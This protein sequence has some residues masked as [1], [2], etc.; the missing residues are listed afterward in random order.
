MQNNDISG[1]AAVDRDDGFNEPYLPERYRQK[2]RARQ[3]RRRIKK[4][5]TG[6]VDIQTGIVTGMEYRH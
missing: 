3:Q 1:E 5:V 4:I 2:V 6:R